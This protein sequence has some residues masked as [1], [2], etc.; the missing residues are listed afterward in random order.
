MNSFGL[1]FLVGVLTA[2]ILM[3]LWSLLRMAK[4]S[5]APE[6]KL[7]EPKLTEEE[8]EKIREEIAADSNAALARRFLQRLRDNSRK[9]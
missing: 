3:V 9:R 1:G 2:T 5:P 4:S 8:K 6:Q 7:P